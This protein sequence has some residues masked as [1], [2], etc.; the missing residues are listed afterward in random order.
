MILFRNKNTK[1]WET[2]GILTSYQKGFPQFQKRRLTVRYTSD[3]VGKS[4]SIA[5]EGNGVMF[6]VP[7]DA[8]YHEITK[9]GEQ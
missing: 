8:I 3:K 7:F 5:D 9:G 4:L 6:Q 1:T 2:E